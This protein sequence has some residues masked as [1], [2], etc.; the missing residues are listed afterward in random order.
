MKPFTAL[1]ACCIA[2][3]T[4]IAVGDPTTQPADSSSQDH[5]TTAKPTAAR[6]DWRRLKEEQNAPDGNAAPRSLTSTCR[7]R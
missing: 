1:L 7:L 6:S 4:A 5:A 3:L 2:M